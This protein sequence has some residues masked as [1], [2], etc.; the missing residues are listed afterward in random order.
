[1]KSIASTL[2]ALAA[3]AASVFATDN[4]PV[5]HK[6]DVVL[7]QGDSITDGGRQRTG[8]DYNHTMGQ[9]YACIISAQIG[10]L[11]PER[12]LTFINRGLAA[13]QPVA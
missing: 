2:F 11:Y 3:F 1:M 12:N 4:L 10:A 6:D 9:C 5:L 13:M 8:N 7:F